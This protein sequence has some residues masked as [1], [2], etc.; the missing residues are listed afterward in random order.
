[1][2]LNREALHRIDQASPRTTGGG[3]P[4]DSSD[5]PS[6]DSSHDIPDNT[7]DHND[8]G[9]RPDRLRRLCRLTNPSKT[10]RQ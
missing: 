6:D 2:A 4:D 8:P 7:S 5:D 1:M 10:T 3:N 9:H